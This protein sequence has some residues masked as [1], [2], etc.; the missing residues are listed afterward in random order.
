MITNIYSTYTESDLLQVEG[1]LDDAGGG[2]PHPQ[3]VLLARQVVRHR[4]AVNV[5]QVTEIKYF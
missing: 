2:H 1:V 5:G 3:D 4:Y